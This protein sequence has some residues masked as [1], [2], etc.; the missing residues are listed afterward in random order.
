MVLKQISTT[1]WQHF[2]RT[3]PTGRHPTGSQGWNSVRIK[4]NAYIELASF[5]G[6]ER[7]GH[8]SLQSRQRTLCHSMIIRCEPFPQVV[9][10]LIRYSATLSHQLVWFHAMQAMTWF[11]RYQDG[12][13]H[14]QEEFARCG[15]YNVLPNGSLWNI[16]I[17]HMYPLIF[18]LEGQTALTVRYNCEPL[19]LFNLGWSNSPI[20]VGAGRHLGESIWITWIVCTT[21]PV[22]WILRW[23]C[24]FSPP[25]LFQMTWGADKH[26]DSCL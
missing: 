20:Q 5:A 11:R 12:L 16:P 1:I 9:Q 3:S 8:S 15:C 6:L 4:N 2:T 10:L 26:G 22:V 24:G 21:R 13:L 17:V 19:C 23:S 14:D 18:I 25:L 7:S